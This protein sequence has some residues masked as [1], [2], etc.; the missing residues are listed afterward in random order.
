VKRR[1][2]EIA[3][4][5]LMPQISALDVVIRVSEAAYDLSFAQLRDEVTQAVSRI[6]PPPNRSEGA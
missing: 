6:C 1:L 3:R 4:V 5:E 2:R